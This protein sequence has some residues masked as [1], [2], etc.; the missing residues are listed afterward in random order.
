MDVIA[1]VRNDSYSSI[2]EL[3]CNVGRTCRG[4][5]FI[6]QGSPPRPA[7]KKNNAS[8]VHAGEQVGSGP[9]N[10]DELVCYAACTSLCHRL[11]SGSD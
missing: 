3:I 10:W 9:A 8:M 4:S 1:A 11:A 2:D 5:L 6:L 7:M